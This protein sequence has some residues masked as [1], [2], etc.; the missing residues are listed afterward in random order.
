MPSRFSGLFDTYDFFGKAIP[1]VVLMIGFASLLPRDSSLLVLPEGANLRNIATLIIAGAALG[2]IFGEGIHNLSTNIESAFGALKEWTLDSKDTAASGIKNSYWVLAYLV[3]PI[4]SY[5][6]R[7]LG[8]LL[9]DKRK[10]ENEADGQTDDED[11][12]KDFDTDSIRGRYR[13]WR[14][15]SSADSELEAYFPPNVATQIRA[16]IRRRGYEI[17][18][19]LISHRRL[20]NRKLEAEFSQ[21]ENPK[22][23]EDISITYKRLLS[24]VQSAYNYNLREEVERLDEF[25]TILRS[26]VERDADSRRA[27]VFQSLYS[28]C[29]S[30]WV[31]LAFF[32]IVYAVIFIYQFQTGLSRSVSQLEPHLISNSHKFWLKLIYTLGVAI[33]LGVVVNRVPVASKLSG[34]KSALIY[35]ISV[36]V[37]FLTPGTAEL[38]STVIGSTISSVA[39]I[40]IDGA[41]L[42]VGVFNAVFQSQVDPTALVLFDTLN[43]LEAPFILVMFVATLVFFDASGDYKE[44]YVEYLITEFAEAEDDSESAKEFKI[45]DQREDKES[46]KSSERIRRGKQ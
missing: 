40:I 35:P 10:A 42:A 21:Y 41:L 39:G 44:H 32:S 31:I 37:V 28:F 27:N 25:Y 22:N 20:F 12:G 16:W 9:R 45:V 4:F 24:A 34:R 36:M 3:G 17:D 38:I 1:G 8:E 43:G 23:E 19:G 2:L 30:M 13:S 46:S 33:F 5:Y 18:V 15:R 29:R 6:G 26:S 7:V 14:F 11:V